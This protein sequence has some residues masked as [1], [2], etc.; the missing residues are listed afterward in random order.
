MIVTT[1]TKKKTW[2]GY[3]FNWVADG[4]NSFLAFAT[5]QDDGTYSF[6]PM[7]VQFDHSARAVVEGLNVNGGLTP[8]DIKAR[9]NILAGVFL[10]AAAEDAVT[11]AA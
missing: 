6:R 9:A 7:T 11:V 2:T 8:A 4:G 5:R 3:D 10:V 1:T